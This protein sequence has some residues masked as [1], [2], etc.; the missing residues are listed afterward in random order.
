MSNYK[1]LLF[2]IVILNI[3]NIQ[4]Q[5]PVDDYKLLI[6]KADSLYQNELFIES[7]K[8]Y[9]EAFKTLGWKGY[10]DDQYNAA[11]AWA[12]V[13]NL[14]SAFRKLDRVI[15]YSNPTYFKKFA[16]FS[17][18]IA[19]KSLHQDQRWEDI[20]QQV[21]KKFYNPL[22]LTLDT[23]FNDDQKYRLLGDSII[24]K[25]GFESE[26]LKILF[27]KIKKIDSINLYKIEKIIEEYGWPDKNEVGTQGSTT[28][29]LVI[30]HADSAT[31]VKYLPVLRKA[32]EEGKA[33]NHQLATLE[34]RI[35][36][37]QHGYQVY[38][39]QLGIDQETGKYFVLPI[40]DP[41]EVDKR[42]L[43]LGLGPL[44]EYLKRFGIGN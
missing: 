37:M 15:T 40:Q 28:V 14:D 13:N 39:T 34:D 36:I 26:E 18:E 17:Y 25:Y 31:Q 2:T 43:K 42:R 27:Q 23:I 10:I 16:D 22:I 29:F 30:Q 32:V 38:G 35:A 11:K 12:M 8:A 6:I 7:T 5:N 41:E 21:E 1:C 24:A 9:T 44:S 20:I 4:A 3:Q 33:D 19:F